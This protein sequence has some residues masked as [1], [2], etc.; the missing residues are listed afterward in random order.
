MQSMTRRQLEQ[1]NNSGRD[2]FVLINVLPRD[3]FNT[4]HICTPVNI[5]HEGANS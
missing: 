2:D 3:A 4:A 5:P 1:M